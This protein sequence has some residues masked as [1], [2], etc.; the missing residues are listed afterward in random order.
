MLIF[1]LFIAACFFLQPVDYCCLLL[2]LGYCYRDVSA[3][4]LVLGGT[5]LRAHSMAHHS[6]LN[7]YSFFHLYAPPCFLCSIICVISLMGSYYHRKPV[8]K[9]TRNLSCVI[10]DT[11]HN[12]QTKTPHGCVDPCGVLLVCCFT[13]EKQIP[14][15]HI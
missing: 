1:L 8:L 12:R 7:R 10:T 11:Y 13:S 5:H 6:V 9:I 4:S 14:Q 15:V 2:S 3:L